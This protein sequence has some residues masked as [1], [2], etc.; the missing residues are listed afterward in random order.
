MMDNIIIFA[1]RDLYYVSAVIF[2]VY[3][4]ITTDRKQFARVAVLTA[5]LAFV[6]SLV[7]SALFYNPRP[8]MLPDA[9]ASLIAHAPGNGFPSD[10]ALFTGTL[11]AIVTVFSPYLGAVLWLIAFVVSVARVL[12]GVHHYVDIIAS[13]IISAVSAAVVYC[14]LKRYLNSKKDKVL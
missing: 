13:F 9:P 6:L 2:V 1:A 5:V 3:F 7:A 12:A 10:H 4:F 8:F 14:T 11:A